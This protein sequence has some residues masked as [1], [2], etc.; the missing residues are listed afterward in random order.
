MRPGADR[1]DWVTSSY[2]ADHFGVTL[3]VVCAPMAGVAG[4]RLAAAV[5]EAGGL[6]MIGVGYTASP[7]WITEQ[8]A[9]AA[10][11]GGP[12]GVGFI[13]WVLETNPGWLD[14]ALEAGC[15]LVSLGFGDPEPWVSRVHDGGSLAAVQVGTRVEARRAAAA[16][17]DI[18]VARGSE[19][20]G[21]GRSEVATL[22][23]LQD[24]L[25]AHDLPVLA[26]GGIATAAGLAAV[27]A[28]GAAGGWVGTPFAA[29]AESDNAP[30]IKQAI[31]GAGSDATVYTRAFDIAQ[32]HSWPAEYGG[33]ALANSFTETWAEREPEL[34]QAVSA[35]DKIR[36]DMLRARQEADLSLAPVYAGE[37][38]G[39]VGSERTAGEVLAEL[40]GFR[41][42]L[43][44]AADRHA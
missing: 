19:G 24:V 23:L 22:P 15:G 10:E 6:G 11:P 1:I 5:S 43:R 40:A 14:T 18:L 34:R 38:A 9:I 13:L 4:G 33:R 42:L 37:A 28:A 3:P 27:L 30:A 36:Q 32:G 41:A 25:A 16:G 20:G 17:A 12:V 8:L 7:E 39:L 21:H 31:I 2:L 44:E 26:A 29:C 35:S